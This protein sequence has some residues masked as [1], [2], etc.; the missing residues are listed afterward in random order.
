MWCGGV[1]VRYYTI[2]LYY[3][4]YYIIIHYCYY[5][6]IIILYYILYSSLL[7]SSSSLPSNI[8]SPPIPSSIP[9]LL[10]SSVPIILSPPHSFYTCRYLY[11]LTYILLP[12]TPISS[13]LDEIQSNTLQSL[14]FHHSIST[15]ISFI[16]YLSILTY[17]YLY[18][19]H[20]FIPKY[21]HPAHFIGGMG[22]GCGLSWCFM[23]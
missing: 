3:Y 14:F 6:Y 22:R 15:I 23:F 9:P 7:P 2:I 11:I 1:Y 4:I 12:N 8:L 20:V 5:Y 10:T 13:D 16:L 19:H 18:S 17:A 21:S